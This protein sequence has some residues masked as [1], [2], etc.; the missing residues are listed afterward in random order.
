ML[1]HAQ[2]C[3]SG[4]HT[5]EA[6]KLAVEQLAKEDADERFVIVLS[7]ANFERYGIRPKDFSRL[8][9]LDDRVNVF[10]I[11]IGSLG[12]QAALLKRALPAGKAFVCKDTA[13]IPQ[14][15]QLIF[16]STVLGSGGSAQD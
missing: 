6:T 15:M 16:T 9:T 4:D 12:E 8:M 10:A 11:F 5:L 2:F 3:V 7:D 13:E 14:I 1:A